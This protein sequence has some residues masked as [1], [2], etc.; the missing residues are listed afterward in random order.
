MRKQTK[1]VA[2]L[3]ATA[4]L[5]IGAAM[6]SFAA[7]G[8][9]EEGDSW[10]Y[11]DN[12]ED[13]VTNEW[14][15]SGDDW[16]YLD[17]DGYMATNS[18][19]DSK[20]YVG[21]DGRML[22]NGWAK[23]N[24]DDEDDSDPD[25][26]DAN[27]Y[28]FTNSGAVQTDG[29]KKINGQWYAFDSE[30]KMKYGWYY[31]TENSN[32][33]Y[34][35]NEDEGWAVTGWAKLAKYG[36]DGDLATE[37]D[38]PGETMK[39]YYFDSNGKAIKAKSTDA[40]MK[41]KTINGYAYY[42]DEDGIMQDG[43]TNI[44]VAT[45]ATASNVYLNDDGALITGWVKLDESFDGDVD[46]HREDSEAWFYLNSK[47][48]PYYYSGKENK[49]LGT[50]DGVIKK[51]NNKYYFLDE[52][53]EMA[54]GLVKLGSDY[55]Y[56]GNENDGS[57]KTGKVTGVV[58]NDD[59]KYTYYFE[60]SGNTKG[61]GYTGIKDGYIYWN[62]RLLTAEE[63]SKYQVVKLDDFGGFDDNTNMYL[64][65]ESGKI[66]KSAKGKKADNG[67]KYWTDS[68]GVVE[69]GTD[70]TNASDIDYVDVPTI[71]VQNNFEWDDIP[72]DTLR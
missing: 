26:E 62:G 58:E 28:Y 2:V 36:Q 4:L 13:L 47:G 56:F 27:W 60:T 64:I 33:F 30:G 57:M 16:Y 14:K 1:L 10:V 15:K 11:Y 22:K 71:E 52:Y 20:Y 55:Y 65:N 50:T 41:K 72:M 23:F 5:A 54:Y 6:T 32:Y 68:N 37:Q 12:D 7:T 69:I 67:T 45:S 46:T 34:L 31:D 61:R 53:G 24:A 43:W 63:D 44:V 17:D 3:S 18:F 48:E 66:Q 21:E 29:W 9:V 8:W 42:F 25:S 49:R 35:G 51:I 70:K 59:E 19:I 39:W 40:K 38:I